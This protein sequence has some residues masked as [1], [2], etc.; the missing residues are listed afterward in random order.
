VAHIKVTNNKLNFNIIDFQVS[1]THQRLV[2]E[3]DDLAE[4]EQQ[5]EQGNGDLF[6]SEHR[7]SGRIHNQAGAAST[8]FGDNEASIIM[9]DWI[10]VAAGIER[11]FFVV[12]A[13]G[14][15]IITSVYV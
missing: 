13:I 10:M 4:S 3:L 12:Y 2:V 6:R 5:A 14:F 8:L 15:A 1:S 7:M 11:L 9:R